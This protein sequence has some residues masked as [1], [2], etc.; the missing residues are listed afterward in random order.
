VWTEDKD[1]KARS[2]ERTPRRT[3]KDVGHKMAHTR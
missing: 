3:G 2:T 1:R